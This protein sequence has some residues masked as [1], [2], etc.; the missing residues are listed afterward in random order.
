MIKILLWIA[1]NIASIASQTCTEKH[2][3]YKYRIR[4]QHY[5]ECLSCI[6]FIYENHETQLLDCKIEEKFESEDL[7]DDILLQYP[8]KEICCNEH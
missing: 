4:D 8:R 6:N 2:Y 1:L 3:V 5:Y 7:V